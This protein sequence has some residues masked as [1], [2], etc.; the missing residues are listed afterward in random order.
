MVLS[1]VD[2]VEDA[3]AV[4]EREALSLGMWR[5]TTMALRWVGGWLVVLVGVLQRVSA[6]ILIVTTIFSLYEI[7]ARL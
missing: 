6:R 7:S 5:R 4:V 3:I 1:L 2:A